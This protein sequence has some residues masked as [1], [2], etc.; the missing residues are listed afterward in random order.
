[1]TAVLT[2]AV[3]SG[4]TYGFAPP[5]FVGYAKGAQITDEVIIVG[6]GQFPSPRLSNAR[7]LKFAATHEPPQ[8][9][10]DEDMEGLF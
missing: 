6:P 5:C 9:W 3:T 7:L 8:S 2:R 4:D 10:Y 1:M